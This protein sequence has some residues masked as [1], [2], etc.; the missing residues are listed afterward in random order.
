[1]HDAPGQSGEAHWNEEAKAL[2]AGVIL[3]TVVHEPVSQATLAN[4]RDK[5]SDPAE[6]EMTP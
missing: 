5:G 4:V 2:I 3:H 6:G 1:M